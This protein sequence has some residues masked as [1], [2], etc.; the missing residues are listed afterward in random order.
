MLI[1]GRP[2]GFNNEYRLIDNM[3]NEL[4][5]YKIFLPLYDGIKKY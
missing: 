3:D 5:E 1:T 4:R 2:A